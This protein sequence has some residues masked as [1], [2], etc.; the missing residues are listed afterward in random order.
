MFFGEAIV[1]LVVAEKRDAGAAQPAAGGPD[2]IFSDSFF[3]TRLAISINC[4][5]TR[6]S[7]AISF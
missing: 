2:Q 6:S 1:M 3:W 5:Q 4:S 7:S